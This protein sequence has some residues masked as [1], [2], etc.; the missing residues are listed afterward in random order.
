MIKNDKKIYFK[1]F[2][3]IYL[4]K[5]SFVIINITIINLIEIKA[6]ETYKFDN[7]KWNICYLFY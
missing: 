5:Y 7:K 2:E 4:I 1:Y 6:C 3:F